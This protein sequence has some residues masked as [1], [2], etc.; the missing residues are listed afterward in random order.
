MNTERNRQTTE[1]FRNQRE[2]KERTSENGYITQ[3]EI[4][5]DVLGKGESISTD[6]C[7]VTPAFEREG[8]DGFSTGDYKYNVYGK[9][10]AAFARIH[11]KEGNEESG[12]LKVNNPPNLFGRGGRG[13]A[14]HIR[15]IEGYRYPNRVNGTHDEKACAL[16]V[17]QFCQTNNPAFLNDTQ[18][19]NQK[20][21]TSEREVFAENS[22]T[23]GYDTDTIF[24]PK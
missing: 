17:D 10:N 19:V 5:R 3:Y 24:P 22:R 15:N 9:T 2:Y 16:G 13:Y 23:G 7:V 12:V 20:E 4:C 21:I 11:L 18:G 14:T 1:Y 8:G 6:A